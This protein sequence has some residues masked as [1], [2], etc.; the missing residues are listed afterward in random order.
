MGGGARLQQRLLTF[1]FIFFLSLNYSKTTQNQTNEESI[2][3][4][5]LCLQH[6]NSDYISISRDTGKPCAEY[7]FSFHTV[8]PLPRPKP[9]LQASMLHLLLRGCYLISY[10]IKPAFLITTPITR[11]TSISQY[12]KHAQTT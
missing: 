8:E 10:V 1:V 7:P 4:F 11:L 6:L 2:L 12:T 5:T 9:D 3:H